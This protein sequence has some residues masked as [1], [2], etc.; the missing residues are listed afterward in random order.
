MALQP[1]RL[2]ECVGIPVCNARSR[3]RDDADDGFCCEVPPVETCLDQ[4]HSRW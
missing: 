4:F 3:R 2:D 1:E